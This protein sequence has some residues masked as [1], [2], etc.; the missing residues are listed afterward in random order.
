[1]KRFE[2]REVCEEIIA[3]FHGQAIGEEGLLLQVRYADTPAQKDLKR[4][5]TERR[6]FR[7]QEYNVGAYG[8]NA[9]FL[10][11]TPQLASPV[12][13]RATQIARHFP[14]SRASS[15]WKREQ[16]ER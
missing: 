3:R 9:E 11:F 1:M 15:S 6:Q 4:I 7:T 2:S 5:T 13:P 12:V 8:T 14:N 10:T 16:N